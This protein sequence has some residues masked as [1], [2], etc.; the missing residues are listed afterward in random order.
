MYIH[1]TYHIHTTQY[2]MNASCNKC[3]LHMHA[4]AQ[5]AANLVIACPCKL[6]AVAVSCSNLRRCSMHEWCLVPLTFIGS[7]YTLVVFSF[8]PQPVQN[9]TL[10]ALVVVALCNLHYII[11][12]GGHFRCST[13]SYTDRCIYCSLHCVAVVEYICGGGYE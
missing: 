1:N 2:K 10:L 12:H 8:D 6:Y 9:S 13:S 5:L 11:L 4:W 7:V 3:N